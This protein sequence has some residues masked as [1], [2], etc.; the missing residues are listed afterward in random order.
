MATDFY[1]AIKD[2]RSYYA[3][4]KESVISDQ[5]IEELV[6]FAVKHTPSSFNSQTSRVLILL[7]EQ[8]DKFWEL[9]TETL[10]KNRPC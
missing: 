7:K 5:R 2:R 6:E 1:Q 10:K 3:I 9:T 4:S 8:H